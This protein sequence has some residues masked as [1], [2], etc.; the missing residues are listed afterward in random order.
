MVS[1]KFYLLSPESVP[2]NQCLFPTFVR[3]FLDDGHTFVHDIRESDIVLMDL[4]T[5]ISG[6]DQKDIDYIVDNC[7]KLVLFDE[8]DRGGMSMDLYPHPLTG[9]QQ[10][11]FDLI[12]KGRIEN[13]QFCRLLDKTK[14]RLPNLYPYEKGI[15]YEEPPVSAEE[16]FN[17]EYDICFLAN[18]SPNREAIAKSL[19]SDGRLKCD[20]LIGGKKI[21]F[22][23]FV[24]RHKKAKL[25]VSSSAGGFTDERVQCLFSVAGLIRQRTNQLLLHDF[26]HKENCLRIDSP[27]TPQDLDDIVE[28]VNNKEKLYEIYQNGVKF[29][30][31]FY[32]PD[33]IAKDILGKIIKHLC[34]K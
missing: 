6:Y 32:S 10:K 26:T 28:I 14:D 11:I 23:D 33:Y 1:M 12:Y 13:V 29:V 17:R 8:Y 3:T 9:Q 5:R 18:S 19:Q 30:K 4:H 20:I 24:A 34:H 2:H 27:P 7:P 31:T 21:D 16:L 22:P 15:F 25:F